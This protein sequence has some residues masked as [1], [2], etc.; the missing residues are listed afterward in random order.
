MFNPS[1]N[2]VR[3]FFFTTYEKGVGHAVLTDLEKIAYSVILEHPE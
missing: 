3:N 2:D 1:V